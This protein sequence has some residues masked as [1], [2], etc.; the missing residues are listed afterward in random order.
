MLYETSS[1]SA[2]AWCVLNG[3]HSFLPPTRFIPARAEPHLVMYIHNFQQ[4]AP[5]VYKVLNILSTHEWMMACVKLERATGG[6]EPGPLASEAS[7][8]PHS[9]LLSIKGIVVAKLRSD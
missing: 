6:V 7:V 5:S 2:Q 3:I 9:H 8:L 4:Q 1:R